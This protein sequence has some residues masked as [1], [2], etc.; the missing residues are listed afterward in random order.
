[1]SKLK[2]LKDFELIAEA[3]IS[4]YEDEGLS[5]LAKGEDV[6]DNL[7]KCNEDNHNNIIL[8]NVMVEKVLAKL[9]RR[10]SVSG[11]EELTI[12]EYI[13]YEN[14]LTKINDT[15][16]LQKYDK[17]NI[18]KPPFDKLL[19]LESIYRDFLKKKYYI[20]LSSDKVLHL[21]D[22]GA[23]NYANSIYDSLKGVLDKE[24]IE[25]VFTQ[26]LYTVQKYTVLCTDKLSVLKK[27]K[28]MITKTMEKNYYNKAIL[29]CSQYLEKLKEEVKIS[30]A[31]KK[32]YAEIERIKK[33][34]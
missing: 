8:L 33:K 3:T 21:K 14:F 20:S 1:M 15:S 9:K 5:G 34:V 32:I 26:L 28:Y 11:D 17:D 6:K 12:K 24:E 4:N 27:V 7:V 16:D 10:E 29:E 22:E 19:L 31:F 18:E 30:D 2:K 13:G 25:N 23:K